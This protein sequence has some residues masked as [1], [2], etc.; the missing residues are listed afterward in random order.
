MFFCIMVS[1]LEKNVE[2]VDSVWYILYRQ[3]N[4]KRRMDKEDKRCRNILEKMYRN[5][6]LG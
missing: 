3:I 1:V 4:I 2:F 6:A 5:S